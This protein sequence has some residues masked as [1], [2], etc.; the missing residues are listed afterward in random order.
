MM[1]PFSEPIFESVGKRNVEINKYVGLEHS[2]DFAKEVKLIYL[3]IFFIIPRATL[4]PN[5]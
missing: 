2:F 1:Q 3:E 4:K 5:N